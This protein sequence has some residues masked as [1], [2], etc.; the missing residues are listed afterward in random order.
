MIVA[1]V[2]ARAEQRRTRLSLDLLTLLLTP[3]MVQLTQQAKSS[4]AVLPL[5]WRG[6]VCISALVLSVST[7]HPRRPDSC[8][9][10]HQVWRSFSWHEEVP[11]V[12][13]VLW[14]LCQ[15]V[16]EWLTGSGSGNRLQGL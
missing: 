3:T 10:H 14:N 12:L 6:P 8:Y 7:L 15:D 5:L 16:P 1:A 4:V 2:S 11:R 13:Q 9:T